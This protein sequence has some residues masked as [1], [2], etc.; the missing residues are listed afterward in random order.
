[1]TRKSDQKQD[2]TATKAAA[3]APKLRLKKETVSDLPPKGEKSGAVKG[4]GLA[5]G[6]CQVHAASY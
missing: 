4:G 3:K 6:Q 5:H 2:K 1:M